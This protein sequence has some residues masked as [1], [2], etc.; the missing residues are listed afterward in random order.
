MEAQTALI[1][2]DGTVELYTVAEVHLH[3]ALVVNPR[4]AECNDA[5]RFDD[6]LYDLGLL[7]LWMLIIDILD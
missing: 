1:R 6:A 3:F 5:L 4:H 2:T 7:K